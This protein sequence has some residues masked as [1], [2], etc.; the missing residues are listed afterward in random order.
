MS[1]GTAAITVSIEGVSVAAQVTV[2]PVP[3]SSV[4]LAPTSL[5]LVVGTTGTLVAT[6]RSAVGA[7][8]GGR[9]VT[10]TSSTPTVATVLNG[11]VTAIAPGSTT[12]TATSEGIAATANVTVTPVPVASIS[13]TPTLDSL[14][15]G[16]TRT[17]VATARDAA[18]NVLSGRA[19]TWSSS[20]ISVATVQSG[21]VNAVAPGIAVITASSDGKSGTATITVTA[22]APPTNVDGRG[23]FFATGPYPFGDQTWAIATQSG[24][25]AIVGAQGPNAISGS[26]TGTLLS[27]EITYA[28]PFL[29]YVARVLGTLAT[30]GT[31]CEVSGL[32]SDTNFSGGSYVAVRPGP[33]APQTAGGNVLRSTLDL[34][35]TFTLAPSRFLGA[36]SWVFSSQDLASGTLTGT[37][38]GNTI[39][40]TV[41]GARLTLTAKDPLN[42]AVTLTILG[43][44]ATDGGNCRI[45]GI[46]VMDAANNSALF[47]A[48]RPGPCTPR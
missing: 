15:V 6:P 22:P 11:V 17:L 27:M 31:N 20:A 13:I 37:Q 4:L 25:G 9:A 39:T 2:V 42:A 47:S 48:V 3:V 16:T 5:S 14:V 18:G 40:G 29:G 41:S 46:Y 23:A 45:T 24:S 36:V 26:I 43:T 1:P 44:A 34:R 30:V 28:A 10:W 33:C 35:G 38:L 8:L 7:T 19:I 32:W 12:V 21:V